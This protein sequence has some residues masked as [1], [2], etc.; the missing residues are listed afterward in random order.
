MWSTLTKA[1]KLCIKLEIWHLIC[2]HLFSM[3]WP[4]SWSCKYLSVIL[5]ANAG[6][7]LRRLCTSLLFYIYLNLWC[8]IQGY[9]WPLT[10]A[11]LSVITSMCCK[12][13]SALCLYVNHWTHYYAEKLIIAIRKQRAPLAIL[14]YCHNCCSEI[15]TTSKLFLSVCVVY[16]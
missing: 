4:M 14:K 10:Y 16:P 12:C 7:P 13:L 1:C 8:W 3:V 5:V 15:L 11:L 2:M 6:G 9:A